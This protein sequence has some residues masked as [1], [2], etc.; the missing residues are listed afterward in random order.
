MGSRPIKNDKKLSRPRHGYS[1]FKKRAEFRLRFLV[2]FRLRECELHTLMHT[3]LFENVLP[4][5]VS[6]SS[7]FV[8]KISAIDINFKLARSTY[9][10]ILISSMSAQPIWQDQISVLESQVLV[11]G[12]MISM[13]HALCPMPIPRERERHQVRV[14][15]LQSVY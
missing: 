5:V 9:N 14:L 10:T 8:I 4:H 12:E 11:I 2:L 15:L 7:E 13:P 3:F 6:I 1:F